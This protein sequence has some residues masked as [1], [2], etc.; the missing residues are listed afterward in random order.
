MDDT[1]FKHGTNDS[2]EKGKGLLVTWIVDTRKNLSQF[3]C[4]FFFFFT[5]SFPPLCII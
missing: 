4:Y 2:S 3:R 5:F 1:T